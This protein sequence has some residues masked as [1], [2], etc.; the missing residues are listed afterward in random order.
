MNSLRQLVFFA[1]V[2]MCLIAHPV[3]TLPY[4]IHHN[5]PNAGLVVS[6][7]SVNDESL[8]PDIQRYLGMSI[9]HY[10]LILRQASP[11]RTD[12]PYTQW[13]MVVITDTEFKPGTLVE[14]QDPIATLF[15]DWRDYPFKQ[16]FNELVIADIV[17]ELSGTEAFFESRV[18]GP[19]G[20]ILLN[21]S[22]ADYYVG[23]LIFPLLAVVFLRRLTFWSILLSAWGYAFGQQLYNRFALIHHIVV[24]VELKMFGA[25]SFLWAAAALLLWIYETRTAHGQRVSERVFSF[26]RRE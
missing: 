16:A 15:V 24:P 22:M 21:L 14:F 3:L 20:G 10:Y 5:L 13:I 17:V 23:P 2:A 8:T 12:Q 25:T 6:S 11:V 9:P 18:Y 7:G 19:N 4:V 26:G 1:I